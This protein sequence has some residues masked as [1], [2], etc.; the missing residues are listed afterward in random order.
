[1]VRAVDDTQPEDA[2]EEAGR[3]LGELVKYLEQLIEARRRDKRND[4]LGN[5]ISVEEKGDRLSTSELITMIALLINAGHETTTSLIG[6][7]VLALLENRAQLD[8]LRS[9][10]ELM[11]TAVEE[12]L[13]H[14]S[15][16][17][18]LRRYALADTEIGGKHVKKG[19]AVEAII[20]AANR[21][22]TVFKDPENL[23]ITRAI[24]PH[25]AFGRGIHLCLG[26]PLV[27]VEAPVAFQALL[28]RFPHLRLDGTPR[29]KQNTRV[30]G[31][32]SLPLA[33]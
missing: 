13:R 8:L 16:V 27:R 10:K 3:G 5:L 29:W 18:R 20:A 19:D 12:L 4:L 32:A 9:E 7:G 31:L 26:A 25:L 14:Q 2:I 11:R 22:R 6:T 28:Q 30:R 33:F 24:N 15:P 1:M 21:D 17:Q 23:D